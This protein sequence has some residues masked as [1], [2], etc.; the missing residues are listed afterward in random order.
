MSMENHTIE[1]VAPPKGWSR[2]ATVW[3]IFGTAATTILPLIA[4]IF[5]IELP[6]GVATAIGTETITLIQA[7]AGLTGIIVALVGRARAK[8]PL[9]LAP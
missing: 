7:A 6:P 1:Q 3:G 5:G 4:P 8:G 9:T 2:S